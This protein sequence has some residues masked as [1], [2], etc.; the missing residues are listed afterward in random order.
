MARLQAIDAGMNGSCTKGSC[1]YRPDIKSSLSYSSCVTG[2]SGRQMCEPPTSTCSLQG[3]LTGAT[4]DQH[5]QG[6]GG[7]KIGLGRP[8]VFHRA[9]SRRTPGS[10]TCSGHTGDDHV[11]R[12]YEAYPHPN[13]PAEPSHYRGSYGAHTAR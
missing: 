1:N 10:W 6:E 13:H 9:T 11:K 12:L 3:Q 5:L 7:R 4:P 2:N 8:L